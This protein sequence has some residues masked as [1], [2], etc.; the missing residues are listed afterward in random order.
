MAEKLAILSDPT[1]QEYYA[2]IDHGFQVLQPKNIPDASKKQSKPNVFTIGSAFYFALKQIR[3]EYMLFLEA[4]FKIDESLSVQD[5]QSQLL[6]AAG[7]LERGAMIVRLLSRKDQ[8]CGTFKDCNHHG[9]HLQATHPGERLR[10]WFAFYCRDHPNT[11][12]SVADCLRVPD[13][14]CFTSWDSNWTLNAVMVKKSTMLNTRY[15]AGNGEKVI[16]TR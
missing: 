9:I 8:G 7:M 2:S 5:I 1:P 12:S 3:Q 13:F 16:I 11:G 14:R 6:A 4:D 15:P 10:N